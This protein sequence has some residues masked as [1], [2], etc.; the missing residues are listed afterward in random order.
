VTV[1]AQLR[2]LNHISPLRSAAVGLAPAWYFLDTEQRSRHQAVLD[3]SAGDP[4]GYRIVPDV[5][6][7]VLRHLFPSLSLPMIFVIL[8]LSQNAA[9]FALAA[10]YFASFG[11]RH[12][13]VA[14][15]LAALAWSFCFAN[16][17][18]GLA[19]DN[20]FDVLFYLVAA[21][22]LVR[23]RSALVMLVALVAAANRET[24]LL[25]P[26]LMVVADDGRPVRRRLVLAGVTL[27]AQL[28]V[29]IAIR[30]V[31]GPQTLILPEGYA[32]GTPLLAYNVGRAVTWLNL[33]TTFL[34]VPVAA[35]FTWRRWPARL[36]KAFLVIVPIW[37]VV[38]FI[39]AIVAETRL[40][41]VPWVIVVLPAALMA[42]DEDG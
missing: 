39:A 12:T 23:R 22:L 8:R 29:I 33:G 19:F 24:A 40:F 5:L 28:A 11:F 42:L 18:A 38:H 14:A 15:G 31:A 2:D 7:E 16:Y 3:H 34:F 13:V 10:S 37:S 4:P 21:T 36:W 9:I 20:Y 6:I 30:L 41:L 17:N 35:A 25:M 27:M 32:P 26:L 1:Y